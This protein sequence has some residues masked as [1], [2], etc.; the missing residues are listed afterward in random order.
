MRKSILET[1]KKRKS[2]RTY[3]QT[4]VTDHDYLLIQDYITKE[5]NLIGPLGRKARFEIIDVANNVSDKGVKLGTYGFIK[6][7]QGYIVGIIENSK[8]GLVEFGYIFEKVILFATQ[9]GVGTCW[10]GGTF[11]RNS[12]E[13]EINLN[14]DEFIPCISPI[15]Y[16]K[17]R[18][19]LFEKTLRYV[20]KA[21]NKKT[22]VELFFD[23]SFEK[24][25]KETEAE[26]F[27]V[28]IEM[29]RLGP[30]ASNKQPWR[31]VLSSDKK[32][33]HFYI[34]HTPNYSGNKLGFDMQLIDIGIAMCHFELACNEKNIEGK[35]IVNDPQIHVPDEHTEYM[36]SWQAT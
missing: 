12:F 34:A 35:W 21:D 22:W 36:I 31:L 1:I 17:G 9:L 13:Q 5:E 26:A 23:G 33:C 8:M 10:I 16:A 27:A 6:N 28:P 32:Q 29:V 3:E 4:P 20:T 7:H 25:L 14:N 11:N 15:G 24:T 30:S 2:I 19:R 18:Q